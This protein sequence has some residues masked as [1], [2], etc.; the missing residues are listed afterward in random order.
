MNTFVVV[1]EILKYIIKNMFLT[2]EITLEDNIDNPFCRESFLAEFLGLR[3]S[4][5]VEFFIG[6]R[7]FMRDFRMLVRPRMFDQIPFPSDLYFHPT[8]GFENIRLYNNFMRKTF[9]KFSMVC[10]SMEIKEFFLTTCD[11]Y[12]EYVAEID[13]FITRVDEENAIL[14]LPA[15]RRT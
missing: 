14:G 1:V 8:F 10:T 2:H 3:L 5:V 12:C 15:V 4:L 11:F 6:L 13:A 7:D 9:A